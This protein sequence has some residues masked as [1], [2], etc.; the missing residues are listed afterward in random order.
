M[1]LLIKYAE[2]LSSSTAYP[3]SSTDNHSSSGITSSPSLI[4]AFLALGFF[5]MA[6]GFVIG[7]RRY[8]YTHRSRRN[9]AVPP[10]DEEIRTTRMLIN[11]K[12]KLWDVLTETTDVQWGCAAP[13]QRK[14]GDH[15]RWENIMVSTC[16][17]SGGGQGNLSRSTDHSEFLSLYR[18]QRSRTATPFRPKVRHRHIIIRTPLNEYE[19]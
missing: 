19:N 10:L 9:D 8:Q 12:P 6:M 5:T 4:L 16:W 13:N 1:S 7:F 18:R 2:T 15:W 14:R 11:R 3:R 17:C